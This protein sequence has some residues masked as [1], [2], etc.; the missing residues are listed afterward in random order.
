MEIPDEKIAMITVI[1]S[2]KNF[3]DPV[4]MQSISDAALQH[5]KELEPKQVG[6]D[7][8]KF[9][10]PQCQGTQLECCED[11]PYVSDITNIDEDGDFD[12]GEICASGMVER[13]QCSGCGYVLCREDG[14]SIDD[15]EETVE[16]CKKNCNQE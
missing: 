6:T 13:I 1:M 14:S 2:L 10:C 7:G 4:A 12:Y 5:K 11:G 8:V 16:W 3:K 15:N 9:L